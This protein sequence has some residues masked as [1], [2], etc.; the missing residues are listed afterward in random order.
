M[1]NESSKYENGNSHG[2]YE[3]QDLQVSGVLYFFLALRVVVV[4]LCI[5]GLLTEVLC[6]S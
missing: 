6:I 1:S 4:A 3:H 5:F 2:S